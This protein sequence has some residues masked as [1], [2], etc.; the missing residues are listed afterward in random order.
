MGPAATPADAWDFLEF[1]AGEERFSGGPGEHEGGGERDA[2]LMHCVVCAV[3]PACVQNPA[4]VRTCGFRG[5]GYDVRRSQN[6]D[7]LTPTGFLCALSALRYLRPRGV[8]FFAPPCNTWV[9][10][11]GA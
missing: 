7:M 11:W 8:A 4:G 9:W 1:F 2:C 3:F 6:Y 5:R 10:V